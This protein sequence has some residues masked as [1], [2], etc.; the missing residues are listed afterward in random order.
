M[1]SAVVD[2]WILKVDGVGLVHAKFAWASVAVISKIESEYLSGWYIIDKTLNW[3][4][5]SLGVALS[6]L[7]PIA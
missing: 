1:E 7:N 5:I 3:V 4:L 6:S 2:G